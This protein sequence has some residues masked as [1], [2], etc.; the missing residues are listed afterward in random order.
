MSAQFRPDSVPD[1]AVGVFEKPS[2]AL[3]PAKVAW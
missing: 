2:Y 3:I 1:V